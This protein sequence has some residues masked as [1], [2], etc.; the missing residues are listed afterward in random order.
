M[1]LALAS[2]IKSSQS[3]LEIDTSLDCLVNYLREKG[4]NEEIFNKTAQVATLS[5]ACL[6]R[7]KSERDAAFIE[8]TSK[9][10]DKK[11][12]KRYHDCFVDS[13]KNDE[14]FLLLQMKR[15][16][17]D[18]IKMSWKSK[19]NPKNWVSS[20]KKKALKSVDAEIS[21]IDLPNLFTCE[22]SDKLSRVYDDLVDRKFTIGKPQSTIDN[23]CMRNFLHKSEK[24][25]QITHEI[26]E[27]CDEVEQ[28]LKLNVL[29]YLRV[30]FINKKIPVQNCIDEKTMTDD[31]YTPFFYIESFYEIVVRD[32]ENE[33]KKFVDKLLKIY[34]QAYSKCI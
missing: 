25:K 13:I 10:E 18:S 6:R 22:Y 21:K 17:I 9:Y 31:V 3:S 8:S 14:N 12:F 29:H 11:E 28:K 23:V 30:L 1:P 7:I 4:M 34:K 33:K 16:A 19:L 5:D 20:D 24:S 2:N 32:R 27:D 26:A 15:K